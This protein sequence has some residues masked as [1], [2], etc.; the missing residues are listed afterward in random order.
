MKRI[1]TAALAAAML[2][3]GAAVVAAP[4]AFAK[5]KEE[6][7]AG[8]QVSAA[9][10]AA[11]NSAKAAF[12][13]K[14]D[15]ASEVAVVQM[16]SL[17][18][19][20]DEKYYAQLARYE[21]NANR[22]AAKAQGTNGVYDPST[23]VGPLDALLAN[24]KL[25]ADKV[26]GYAYERGRLAYLQKQYKVAIDNLNRAK[27]AGSVDPNLPLL[28]VDAKQ[29]AGDN[30]GAL[31]ELDAYYASGKPMTEDQ[32]K[33]AFAHAAQANLRGDTV[34]WLQRWV[35]GIPTSKSWRDALSYYGYSQ[36]PVVTLDKYQTI[37][38]LRLMRQTH[39]LADQYTYEAFAQRLF[40][41]GLPDEAKAVVDEGR[42]NGKIPAGSPAIAT[43]TAAANQISSASALAA[44]AT[45]A[46]A[47]ANGQLSQQTADVYLGRG[48]YAKAVELYRQS[49]TKGGVN[50]DQVNTDLGIALALSGD[51]VGA[52][53]AF[54]LVKTAPRSDIAGFWSTWLDHPPTS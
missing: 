27:A 8:P 1:S 41:S 10:G 54:D 11:L 53:A 19:S 43:G 39:A 17:A 26:A 45:K 51:K 18:K 13:A 21:L 47:S 35:A 16:E 48:D 33:Y 4:P 9:F 20:D 30:S 34:K 14:D 6:A 2:A 24:P 40:N 46:G 42:A 50:A 29:H 22:A 38:L 23:V 7:P 36:K 44:L 37:D 49:L 25:P 28:L 3:G 5:K 52:K 15:T 32:Y 12:V 31:S